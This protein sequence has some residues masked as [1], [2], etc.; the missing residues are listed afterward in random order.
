MIAPGQA[1]RDAAASAARHAQLELADLVEHLA[2]ARLGGVGYEERW[3]LLHAEHMVRQAADACRAA[4]DA[5]YRE[6]ETK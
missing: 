4:A 5:L 2:Q 1:E 6:E 3:V